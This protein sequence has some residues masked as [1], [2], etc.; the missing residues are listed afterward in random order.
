MNRW[1]KSLDEMQAR[2]RQVSEC[3][4]A[5]EALSKVTSCFQQL[6]TSLGSNSDGGFLRE[7]MDETR[8]QAHRICTGL[9]RRLVHLLVDAEP[10]QTEPAQSEPCQAE[11]SQTEPGNLELRQQAERLWVLFYSSLETFLLDLYKTRQLIG[12][13]PLTQRRDRQALVNTG[14]SDSVSGVAA[15]AAMV[16]TPWLRVE[17]E[18]KPDLQN[19]IVLLEAMLNDMLQK[20]NVAFWAVESTQKA[21]A[22]ALS[23]LTETHDQDDTLEDMM[24]VVAVANDKRFGCCHLSSCKIGCLLCLLHS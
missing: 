18:S 6:A 17:E 22:E 5:T 2:R 20:V 3:E 1:R 13:F 15:R 9:H 4:R 21:W 8:A 24:E 11:V 10:A 14:G 7:E 16:Q 19:H 23:F 12:Q